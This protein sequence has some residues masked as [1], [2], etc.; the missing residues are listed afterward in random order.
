MFSQLVRLRLPP[1]QPVARP[2]ATEGLFF[3]VRQV[4]TGQ[5]AYGG[6]V[7]AIQPSSS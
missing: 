1:P 4:F 6:V 3:A 7:T 2:S 5:T